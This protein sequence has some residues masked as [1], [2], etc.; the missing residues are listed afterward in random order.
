[1]GPSPSTAF[2]AP[3]SKGGDAAISALSSARLFGVCADA[4]ATGPCAADF[5]LTVRLLDWCKTAVQVAM[6][7]QVH[8]RTSRACDEPA[9]ST[10]L[11]STSAIDPERPRRWPRT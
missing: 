11:A 7:A 5:C 2:F 1:M 10:A 9:P 6:L 4:L 3:P 8:W